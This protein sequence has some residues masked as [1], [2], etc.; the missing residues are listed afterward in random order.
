MWER[1]A[2]GS[3]YLPFLNALRGHSVFRKQDEDDPLCLII[4]QQL[5]VCIKTSEYIFLSVSFP[6][7][8][9]F[10]CFYCLNI[11]NTTATE[12]NRRKL[13]CAEKWSKT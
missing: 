6:P 8:L 3:E 1:T 5:T 10:F 2:T 7:M 9:V 12:N 13:I 4:V 11:L